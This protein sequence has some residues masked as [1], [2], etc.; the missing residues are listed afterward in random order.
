MLTV[1]EVARELNVSR[2]TVNQYIKKGLIDAKKDENGFYVIQNRD[3][4][5][6]KEEMRTNEKLYSATEVAKILGLTRPQTLSGYIKDGKIESYT[7]PNG[8]TVI[9]HEE[10]ERL[11]KKLKAS[12]KIVVIKTLVE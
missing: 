11:R 9:P 10:V 4:E 12:K 6:L 1:T 3:F 2:Q 8:R 5:F 7:L